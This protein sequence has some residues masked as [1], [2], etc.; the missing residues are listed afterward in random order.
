MPSRLNCSGFAR[1]HFQSLVSSS[2]APLPLQ[3]N[4]KHCLREHREKHILHTDMQ[5]A[6]TA[7]N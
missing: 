7:G 4:H 6:K 5:C 1:W 2:D 3:G